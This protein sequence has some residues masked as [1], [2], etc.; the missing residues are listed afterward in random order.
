MHRPSIR[1]ASGAAVFAFV[2][3]TASASL[4]AA[5]VSGTVRNASGE[6]VADAR[7][8]LVEL[9][10]AT[11]VG[12]DGSFRFEDVPPGHYHLSAESPRFGSAVRELHA[13]ADGTVAIA[14]VL[15]VSR[16]QET[17]VVSAG[18]RRGNF[19]AYQPIDVLDRVEIEARLQPTL[20]ETLASE[21]G[22]RATSF[23]PGASRPVI[24]G[25]GGGRIRILEGG[26]D[27]GDASAT[28][29]DHAVATD[30]A[31][32]ERIEIL[33][34]PATLL[35]GSNAVGGAINVIDGRIPEFAPK[36]RFAGQAALRYG[37]A[38]DDRSAS[39]DVDG[40][41]GAFAWHVD[42]SAR[43][44]DDYDIP[45]R[46]VAGEPDGAVGTLPGSALESSTATVGG[47]W[48]GSLGFVGVSVRRFDTR[49]GIP[50]ELEEE[51]PPVAALAA[52]PVRAA[53]GDAGVAI[54]L[55]QRRYDLRAGLR[56]DFG[57]FQGLR[58]AAGWTDYEHVELEDGLVGT[59]FRN[60]ASDVRVE[61]PHGSQGRVSGV[62]GVQATRR[63]FEAI[64]DEAFVPP[65]TTDALA[66]FA[67]EEIER[68]PVS[69]EIGLR[70]ENQDVRADGGPSRS[71]DG[72]SGSAGLV[73]RPS[74]GW[75][76]GGSIAQ[77]VRLPGAEELFSDG[78]H[79]A[80]LSYERG[81]PDLREETSVGFDVT[82][83]KRTGRVTGE[84]SAF[85]NAFRD[86]I[87][88]EATGDVEDGLPV[89][90][91]TQGDATFHGFETV[92]VFRLF[93]AERHDLDLELSADRVRASL[94][95]GGEPLPRIP[96]DRVGAAVRYRGDRWHGSAGVSRTRAQD[97]VAATE[98][99]TDGYTLVD[100]A[101]G[102]RFATSGIV[103]D[104]LLRGT[105]LTDE[106]ARPH[107]SRLKEFVPLAGRDLALLY[108]VIF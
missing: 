57:P 15:G 58:V 98:S 77:A 20:G 52:P 44:T 83:R 39:V 17:I 66:L 88:E 41:A 8:V 97:R 61:L 25:Q 9:E 74:D 38:A 78:P 67:V 75:T 28:S 72:I 81:D 80:T 76:V 45:G 48:V 89:F 103:H 13:E 90:R 60:D 93:H 54:D 53:I 40:G 68:G 82:V 104:V 27:V 12:A 2:L 4:E 50:A 26:V 49:Y 23:A 16:H 21:P 56:R 35:Y 10:R 22:V 31:S 11:F 30:P 85:R 43:E 62:V 86:Y 46:A 24:R 84:F 55:A 18:T 37:T 36:R 33:R 51:E 106:V 63:D 101:V 6:P 96:A 19:E 107:T 102:Y 14:V 95:D 79:L 59:R 91:F 105:N 42:A 7:V 100:A 71:F 65:S 34:G 108:R 47:S 29:P 64:G 70:Y 87:Y 73:W 92:V 94:D 99:R 3:A 5:D 32:A 1:A 69:Y